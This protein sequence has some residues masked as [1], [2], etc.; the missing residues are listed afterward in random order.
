MSFTVLTNVN[1]ENIRKKKKKEIFEYN[2]NLTI[3]P[4]FKNLK[5]WPKSSEIKCWNCV[6]PITGR[7]VFIPKHRIATKHVPHVL[8]TTY[9]YNKDFQR[10][11][12]EVEGHFCSF[13]CCLNFI[14]HTNRPECVEQLALLYKIFYPGK[15][16]PPQRR[17]PEPFPKKCH[18]CYLRLEAK[19]TIYLKC[20][21]FCSLPCAV[22]FNSEETYKTF[23]N[24]LF[25]PPAEVKHRMQIFGGDMTVSEYMEHNINLSTYSTITT[26]H[27]KYYLF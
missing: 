12:I 10:M 8:T 9:D 7:P 18:H 16:M 11:E 17:I 24:H 1:I 5:T 4:I 20:G 25:I 22:A 6:G 13:A 14:D 15:I 27:K 21:E 2:E 23:N 3:P 26:K 19:S